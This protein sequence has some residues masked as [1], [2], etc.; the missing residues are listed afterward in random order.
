MSE[1]LS[2]DAKIYYGAPGASAASEL[3]NVIEVSTPLEKKRADL[4][5]RSSGGWEVGRTTLKSGT[6]DV[7]L[8]YD[9][10]DAGFIAIKAA[11]LNNTLIAIWAKDSAGGEGLDADMDVTKFAR[12]EPLPEGETLDVSFALAKSARAPQWH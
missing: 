2:I 8:V 3:L 6:I 12:G 4:T 5:S 10:A 11:F 9:P 1:K 7:K